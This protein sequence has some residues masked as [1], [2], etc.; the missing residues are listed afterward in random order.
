MGADFFKAEFFIKTDGSFVIGANLEFD[1]FGIV[2]SAKIDKE[3]HKPGSDA[4]SPIIFSYGYSKIFSVGKTDSSGNR[5]NNAASDKFALVKSKDHHAVR[6]SGKLSDII[7]SLG[8]RKRKLYL[9][10][11]KGYWIYK[12]N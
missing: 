11:K 1:N 5:G 8:N 3:I 4:F 9:C 10:S 7:R 2:F 6:I 12:F